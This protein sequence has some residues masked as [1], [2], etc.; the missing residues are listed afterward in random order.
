[1]K[2]PLQRLLSIS[3]SLIFSADAE[4]A[5]TPASLYGWPG[6]LG[7]CDK[8]VLSPWDIVLD[9]E[10]IDGVPKQFRTAPRY[11]SSSSSSRTSGSGQ[12]SEKQFL[13]MLKI[14]EEKYSV[15]AEKII[16]V[17]LREEPHGFINGMAVTW[18]IG[19]LNQELNK[20]GEEAVNVEQ[21]KFKRLKKQQTIPIYAVKKAEDGFVSQK[22]PLLTKIDLA[23]S[24]SDLAKTHNVQYLRIPVTDHFKPETKDVEQFLNF[25]HHLPEDTWLHFHCR[26]GKGRT[27]TFMVLYDI[28]KNPS[29]S[30]EDIL[31]HHEL[32]G[33]TNLQKSDHS[34]SKKWAQVL[35]KERLL[36]I[37]YFYEFVH[38]PE[39]YKKTSWSS[40][41][42]K[43]H[44]SRTIGPSVV[45]CPG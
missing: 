45:K 18:Y 27:T 21:S 36:L 31:Q 7:T 4:V 39:G 19:P 17:D 28:I 11:G 29:L 23:Q 40:W 10:N 38:D 12:F 2:K 34:A 1:M 14:L 6:H 5:Y 35:A 44:P 15:P 20:S 30:L 22:K 25:L 42:S 3:I 9:V 43:K 16:L 26:G 24:E 8:F 37:H 33:G 32:S 41:R 13:T